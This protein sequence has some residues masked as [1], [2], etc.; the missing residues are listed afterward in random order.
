MWQ[1]VPRLGDYA[2]DYSE[3]S[4]CLFHGLGIMLGII[5]N[6]LDAGAKAKIH[7]GVTAECFVMLG[8]QVVLR[9]LTGR[10]HARNSEFYSND[11]AHPRAGCHLHGLFTIFMYTHYGI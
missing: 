9:R 11:S 6:C 2:R 3:L 5:Q 1:V 4:G 7:I 8:I 10:S